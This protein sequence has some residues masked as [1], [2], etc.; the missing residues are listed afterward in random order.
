MN[1]PNV[2]KTYRALVN[3][4][5]LKELDVLEDLLVGHRATVA[6]SFLAQ[7][8]PGTR[9]KVEGFPSEYEV[10]EVCLKTMRC[11]VLLADGS[12]TDEVRWVSPKLLSVV[13]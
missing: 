3:V 2:A 9:V 11:R 6:R 5:N 10:A 4:N 12:R 1:S 13:S 8:D 7:L